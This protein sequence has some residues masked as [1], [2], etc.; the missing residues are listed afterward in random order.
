MIRKQNMNLK[1]KNDAVNTPGYFED[2][3]KEIQQ[4]DHNREIAAKL[5]NDLDIDIDL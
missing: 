5:L 4:I 3:L 1:Q 2:S